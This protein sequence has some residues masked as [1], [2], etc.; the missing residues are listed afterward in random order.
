MTYEIRLGVPA[1][2]SSHAPYASPTA[3]V[4]SHSSGYGKPNLFANAAF[5]STVSNEIPRMAA[6]FASNCA[7]RSR[8]PQP[9]IVQPGVSAFG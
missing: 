5:S 9:S 4:V 3:R 6:F 7:F 2:A 1:D 8:Y